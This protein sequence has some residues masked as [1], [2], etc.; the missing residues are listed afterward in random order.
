MKIIWFSTKKIY[1]SEWQHEWY[2]QCYSGG[3][4]CWLRLDF[5]CPRLFRVRYRIASI[6]LQLRAYQSKRN[7]FFFYA[8][9]WNMAWPNVVEVD[10]TWGRRV[11]RSS[12]HDDNRRGNWAWV[13][14]ASGP[15]ISFIT[16]CV[17]VGK[18][19]NLPRLFFPAK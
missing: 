9:Y 14:Q 18:P 17:M 19:V 6:S 8:T 12:A 7:L 15:I 13:T 5:L 3:L 2:L 1:S 10:Q 11:E 16:H 4:R